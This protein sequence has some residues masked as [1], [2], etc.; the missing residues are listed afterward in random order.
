MSSL[1][2]RLTAAIAADRPCWLPGIAGDLVTEFWAGST[3]DPASYATQAWLGSECA[4]AGVLIPGM[5]T[6]QLEPLP[7]QYAD[8]FV[9]P[10][11]ATASQFAPRAIADALTRLEAS[12]AGDPVAHLIRSVHCINARGPGYDCSHSEPSVP[13]SVFVSV[14]YAEPDG[15]LRLAESLLHEAMHLQL[16]LIER[17]VALTR[18]DGE[19]CYSPW[20][21]RQRPLLGLVHGLYV[22][23][24]I[25]G[26]L[27]CLAVEETISDADRAYAH[28][29]LRDIDQE[30]AQVIALPNAAGLTPFGRA[31]VVWLL[32]AT[33]ATPAAATDAR[34]R[35]AAVSSGK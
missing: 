15:E 27:T 24:A 5:G 8:R 10:A 25:H 20:Q 30:I 14:P 16:T 4:R 7:A 12:G 33:G 34:P 2:R 19:Q 11:F 23:A 28:R 6:M 1:E 13:F 22:F 3:F 26:W 35:Q 32:E 9:A 17:Q 18:A 29:R 31:F 21:Q